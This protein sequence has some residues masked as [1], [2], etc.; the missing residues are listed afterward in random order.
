MPANKLSTFLLGNLDES[1]ITDDGITLARLKDDV[2]KARG[3]LKAIASQKIALFHSD[4]YIFLVW[5]LAA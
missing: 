2:A 5:L 4:A 3:S 1:L